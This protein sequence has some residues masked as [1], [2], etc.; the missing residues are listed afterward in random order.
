VTSPASQ[1]SSSKVKVEADKRRHPRKKAQLHVALL[2]GAQ[3][4]DTKLRALSDDVGMGGMFVRSELLLELGE[5]VA[6]SFE[7]P[8]G[9]KVNARGRVIHVQ[10]SRERAGMGIAF[11]QLSDNHRQALGEFLAK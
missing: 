5:E 7:L 2:D 6:L 9:A 1:Q 10:T 11:T 8:G 4:T 3:R